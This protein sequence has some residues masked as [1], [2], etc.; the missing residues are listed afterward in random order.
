[1]QPAMKI[2]VA[3][4]VALAAIPAMTM[5][6]T[7][8]N[9]AGKSGDFVFGLITPL[10][11]AASENGQSYA[12]GAAAGVV[13]LNQTHGVDGHKVRLAVCDSQSLE[14]QAVICAKRLV[15]Q[16]HARVLIGTGSTPQTIAVVPA[17]TA[18]QVPLFAMCGGGGPYAAGKPWGFKGLAGNPDQIP[19]AFLLA[20]RRGWTRV[21]IIHDTGAYGRDVQKT[22]QRLAA[23]NGL[24]IV[25]DEGY[26]ETQT[27]MTPQVLHIRAAKPD[28]VMN[29]APTVP[30]G[31]SIG[32]KLVQ[33]GVTVPDIVGI[34]LQNDQFVH[35]AG[36]ALTHTIFVGPR[37]LLEHSSAA[38]TT[39]VQ[40]L[41]AI[42]LH[43]YKRP[44][45][46]ILTAGP[47]DSMLVVQAAAAH[48][49]ASLSNPQA[50][51]AALDKVS[52]V[53]GIQGTWTFTATNHGPLLGAGITT[54]VY[55]DGAW[56][57]V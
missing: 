17:A 3:A 36:S 35:L 20:K 23:A 12:R 22:M 29:Y 10:T 26:G 53:P 28:V 13:L 31:V 7:P 25:A 1:M 52:D 4:L 24:T 50:L 2:L 21:A 56:H 30:A 48:L 47:V 54:M 11:G 8:A 42:Y 38:P 27:D 57:G 16:D 14:Q 39:N 9:A 5:A 6:P 33:L 32:R 43:M 37:A 40:R 46:D 49:G 15:Y 44:M 51:R 19:P 45:P 41:L 34:N 18:A 55:R